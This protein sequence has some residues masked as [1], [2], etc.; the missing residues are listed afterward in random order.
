MMVHMHYIYSRQIFYNIKLTYI[1]SVIKYLFFFIYA[2]K[3]DKK[4]TV[5]NVLLLIFN[6]I[7][8]NFI[9]NKV[10]KIKCEIRQDDRL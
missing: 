3:S 5:I 9:S 7:E 6:S 8:Q 1:V 2:T 10:L 4:N